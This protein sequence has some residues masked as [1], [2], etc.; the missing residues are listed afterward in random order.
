[1]DTFDIPI[2]KKSYDFYR[3]LNELR[4]QI[5]KQDKHTLWQRLENTALSVLEG[6]LRASSLSKNEKLPIL[7]SASH[8][9]NVTRVF[10]RLAKDTK[11]IDLKRY[12]EFERQIDEI[13]RMLGGWIRQV[14]G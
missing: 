4:V 13:G 6:I 3:H 9:L 10:I 14:K 5:A 8:D 11:M 1:M 2:F 12:E 7:E